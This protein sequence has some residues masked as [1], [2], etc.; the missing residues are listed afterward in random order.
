MNKIIKITLIAFIS[1]IIAAGGFLGYLFARRE[2]EI[3]KLPDYY[4][5]LAE[6][7]KE[8]ESFGCSAR[9]DGPLK[10]PDNPNT[11][12]LLKDNSPTESLIAYMGEEG[13]TEGIYLFNTVTK[14]LTVV[15]ELTIAGGDTGRGGYYMDNRALNFSPTG[16]AFFVNVSGRTHFPSFFI[17]RTADGYILHSGNDLGHATWISGNEV[18]FRSAVSRQP[19]VYDIRTLTSKPTML[20]DGI[21]HLRANKDGRKVMAFSSSE[22]QKC[23]DD[24][25]NLHVYS[26]PN[27]IELFSEFN[28]TLTAAWLDENNITFNKIKDCKKDA[29][30]VSGYSPVTEEK[31][32]TIQNQKF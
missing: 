13:Y 31:Q 23:P 24:N 20:P 8:K 10:T 9:S 1:L 4:Q 27:G 6:M 22:D 14:N 17:I 18:V 11:R 28:V 25:F 12:I 32:I 3:E 30:S 29:D 16:K 21:F 26:Y 7:C 2:Y 5:K 19:H 15:Y